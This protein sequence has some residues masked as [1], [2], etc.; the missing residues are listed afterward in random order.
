MQLLTERLILRRWTS[1]DRVGFAAMSADP[2]VMAWL[3]GVVDAAGA[4]ERI[5]RVER[6]W[7]TVGHSRYAV[8]ER[9]GE[10]FLG[11]CGINPA[12]ETLPVAGRPE[13][14]WRLVRSAWGRGYATEAAR[15]ALTDGF[16]RCGFPEVL[17][18]TNK[19]NLRSQAVMRRLDM[20][21]REDLDFDYPGEAEDSPMRPAVVYSI[22]P[23]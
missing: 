13:I 3:G 4:A 1:A 18:Y 14:G 23:A 2:E 17:A 12:F 16:Q 6:L 22:A 21:R 9:R 11:W 10:A 20:R 5:D 7:E 15:A 19:G 8:V